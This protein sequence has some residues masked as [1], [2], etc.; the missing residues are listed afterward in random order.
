MPR[1]S[2]GGRM[3]CKGCKYRR[4]VHHGGD[5]ATMCHYCYDTG[6]PRGCPASQCNKYA[7]RDSGAKYCADRE[8]RATGG[9]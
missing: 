5:S 6:E 8:L 7:R 3:G 9:V 4:V 1:Q 2:E